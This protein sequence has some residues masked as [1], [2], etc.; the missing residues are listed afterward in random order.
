MRSMGLRTTA[1]IEEEYTAVRAAYLRALE[2][3]EY[4]VGG[5]VQRS[6]KR[7]EV[8]RLREQMEKLE[9]EYKRATGGGI[10]I[11]GVVPSV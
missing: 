7:A 11:F 6:V 5:A 4:T 8:D 3:Q 1:Q 9:R 10:K 2:A